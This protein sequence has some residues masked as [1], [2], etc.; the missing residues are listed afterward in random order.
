MIQAWKSSMFGHGQF[1]IS[2]EICKLHVT[3]PPLE[4]VGQTGRLVKL[5]MGAVR[6]ISDFPTLTLYSHHVNC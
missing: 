6:G 2:V 1:W 5:W 4:G 3:P